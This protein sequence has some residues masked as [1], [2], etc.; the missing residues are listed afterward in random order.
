MHPV[1]MIF[2]IDQMTSVKLP[3]KLDAQKELVVKS[4]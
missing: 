4:W 2:I 3:Q 1:L